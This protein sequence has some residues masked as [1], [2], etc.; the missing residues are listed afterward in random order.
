MKTPVRIYQIS[1]ICILLLLLYILCIKVIP[2]YSNF[3]ELLSLYSNEKEQLSENTRWKERSIDLKLD[4]NKIKKQIAELN[5]DIPYEYEL[6]IPLNFL[7]SL[8]NNNSISFDKL[9]YVSV[10]TVKQYQFVRINVNLKS[11][12]LLLKKLIDQIEKSPLI[13]IV[14]GLKFE[15]ASLFSRTLNAELSL[16]ILLKRK[17]K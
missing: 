13:I 14:E 8:L 6:Y 4:I 5:V 1:T 12:F 17:L 15:L 7:D 16:R 2:E 3:F 10:D 9:E 11:S